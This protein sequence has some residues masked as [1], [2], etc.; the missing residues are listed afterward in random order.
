MGY[1]KGTIWTQE[2]VEESIKEVVEGLD[3]DTMPTANQMNL[4][5][6]NTRLSNKISKSE[7]FNWWAER[8][9]LNIKRSS[10]SIGQKIEKE[11]E[12]FLTEVK[13]YKCEQMPTNFPYDI[14]VNNSTKI[15]VKS[16]HRSGINKDFYT[17]SLGK[18]SSTCDIYVC[19]C[20]NYDDSI[21]KIYVIPSVFLNGITQLSLGIN[22][23]KYD[24]FENKWEYIEKYNAFYEGVRSIQSD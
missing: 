24:I 22:S 12:L 1:S 6:G 14:L 10:T 23:S 11:L 17:F 3:L 9:K 13:G 2:K 15:D 7:G 21:R 4:Y 8:L 19:Y 16:G 5:F 20:L 18:K